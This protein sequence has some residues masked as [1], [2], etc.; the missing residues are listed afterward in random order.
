[1]QEWNKFKFKKFAD[2]TNRQKKQKKKQKCE[3][4]LVCVFI[5]LRQH[6]IK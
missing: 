2:I 1:M 3:R 5:N 4:E 6:G